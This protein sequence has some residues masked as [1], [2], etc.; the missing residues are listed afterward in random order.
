MDNGEL[1]LLHPN[2]IWSLKVARYIQVNPVETFVP[3]LATQHEALPVFH[4][5]QANLGVQ[6][7]NEM[8]TNVFN[9]VSQQ[10]SHAIEE[11][12]QR[13]KD[14]ILNAP[15]QEIKMGEEYS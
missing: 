15:S 11:R 10:N 14:S 8:L 5:V 6:G 7:T 3:L 2:I 12:L 13:L 9:I 1:V 4:T